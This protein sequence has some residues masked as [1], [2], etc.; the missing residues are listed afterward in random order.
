M[1]DITRMDPRANALH[2][3]AVRL[4]LMIFEEAR[5]FGTNPELAELRVR[6]EEAIKL[7]AVD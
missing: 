2:Q 1:Y 3:D 6:M 5:G 4:R 7:L